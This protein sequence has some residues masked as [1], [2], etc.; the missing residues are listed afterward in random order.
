MKK[1]KALVLFSNKKAQENEIS[2]LSM[3]LILVAVLVLGYILWH[4]F[5]NNMFNAR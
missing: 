5:I 4:Y 2:T 1:R 3:V